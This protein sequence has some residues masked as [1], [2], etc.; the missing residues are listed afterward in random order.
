[1]FCKDIILNILLYLPYDSVCKVS[2]VN[3]MFLGT[4]KDYNN[5]FLFRDFKEHKRDYI[6]RCGEFEKNIITYHILNPSLEHLM[7]QSSNKEIISIIEEHKRLHKMLA[8]GL[9]DYISLSCELFKMRKYRSMNY[10]E[11]D[12][13]NFWSDETIRNILGSFA[14]EYTEFSDEEEYNER[15]RRYSKKSRK[16]MMEYMYDRNGDIHIRGDCLPQEDLLYLFVNE[17]NIHL[18]ADCDKYKLYDVDINE[19]LKIHQTLE[20]E[21][22]EFDRGVPG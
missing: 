3:K 20:E 13:S 8:Q 16:E 1:M 6:K 7:K 22:D 10:D 4:I 2:R 18:I 14:L 11:G 21:Y 17:D 12:Y 19:A 5:S 15:I 9:G